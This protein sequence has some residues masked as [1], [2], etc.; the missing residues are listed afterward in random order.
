[1]LGV[2]EAHVLE[3]KQ[4]NMNWDKKMSEYEERA[5]TMAD[6]MKKKHEEEVEKLREELNNKQHK[7]KFST[8]LLKYRKV[9][10]HLV[11]SKDYGEAHK[12]KEKADELEAIE[13]QRWMKK[14]IRDMNRSE[15]Q[16]KEKKKQELIALE[17]R[18]QTGR[19]ELK[20][21]R[22]FQLERLIQRYQNTKNELEAQ[23]NLDR[24]NRSKQFS[25]RFTRKR[26][27]L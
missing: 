23:H 25:A 3:L 2:E 27:K 1:M 26:Q 14:R 10:E 8:E 18:L 6:N 13:T 24:I 4:F 22:Q 7:P 5:S 11:K 16:F 17:K 15:Q 21:Q 20:K 19:E 12:T 9:E